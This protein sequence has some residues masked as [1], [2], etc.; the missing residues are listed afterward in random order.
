MM[1]TI[2]EPT[3]TNP[4][5]ADVAIEAAKKALLTLAWVDQAFGRAWP[6]AMER[7][8]NNK[9]TEPCIYTKGNSYETVVP[10]SD[11]GNYTFFVLVD[12]ARYEVE[13]EVYR[14]PYAL[15]VWYDMRRC[16]TDNGANR[17]D[18][19]N[20]KKDIIDVLT[21]STI[22]KDGR[23]TVNR[24]IENPKSVY[25]EFSFDTQMNQALVQPYGAIRFE[26]EFII[27]KGC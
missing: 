19:E 2:I 21:T 17:R 26:G 10:S 27:L 23:I 1:R 13:T 15:I 7:G 25:K 3:K 18:T 12:A 22:V 11:L 8:N 20:L 5:L 16:F 6:I 4:A 14:Q 9:V 24:V